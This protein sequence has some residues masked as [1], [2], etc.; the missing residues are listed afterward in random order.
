MMDDAERLVALLNEIG[1]ET[2]LT[3][4]N[5]ETKFNFRPDV[6]LR[7]IAFRLDVGCHFLFNADGKLVAVQSEYDDVVEPIG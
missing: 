2:R 5:Y 4:T 7:R 1:L 3:A 6:A